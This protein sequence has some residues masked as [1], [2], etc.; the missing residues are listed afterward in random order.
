MPRVVA[1]VNGLPLA[2]PGVM[3]CP[4]DRGPF[5]EL[6]FRPAGRGAPVA[7][8]VADGGG[9]GLV[10]LRVH[11]RAEPSLTGGPGLIRWLQASI[12]VKLG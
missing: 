6:D 10:T 9:C 5:V 1:Y 4:N 12:G 7:V 11:G 3:A 8:A 2:Q